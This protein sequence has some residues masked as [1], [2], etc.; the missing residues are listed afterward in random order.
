LPLDE[1]VTVIVAVLT[2][3]LTAAV[4]EEQAGMHL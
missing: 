3:R 2:I 4:P 1:L